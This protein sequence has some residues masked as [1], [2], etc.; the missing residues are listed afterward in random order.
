MSIALPSALVAV[1]SVTP[2][3]ADLARHLEICRLQAELEILEG[4]LAQ[5]RASE[6][7]VVGAGDSAEPFAE[8]A[9][10]LVDRMVEELRRTACEEHRQIVGIG[11]AEAEA[12]LALARIRAEEIVSDAREDLLRAIAE[13][14]LAFG[15]HLEV[16]LDDA[17]ADQADRAPRLA[18]PTDPVIALSNVPMSSD[19]GPAA[20][21]VEPE[22]SVEPETRTELEQP[23]APPLLPPIA[24]APV[25]QEPVVET[26][27]HPTSPA[28][29]GAVAVEEARTD[30]AFDVW[31]AVAP[32]PVDPELVEP[33]ERTLD[34]GRSR[35]SATVLAL[36]IG[37]V[38]LLVVTLVVLGLV[39]VG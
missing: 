33:V 3:P 19:G 26:D 17:V 38:L 27:A 39:L 34:D 13:R 6:S 36:E 29:L 16:D 21:D 11:R 8:R 22:P 7:D 1:P 14:D 20:A 25:S 37:G 35:R 18:A 32:A 4:Q 10:E 23:P 9:Q 30:A 5:A 12:R 31:L 15:S 28:P 2:E 24:E